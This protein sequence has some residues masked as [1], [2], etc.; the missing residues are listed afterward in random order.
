[1]CTKTKQNITLYGLFFTH[2]I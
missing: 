2:L 1:M